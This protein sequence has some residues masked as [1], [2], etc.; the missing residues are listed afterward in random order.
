MTKTSWLTGIVHTLEAY[1]VPRSIGFDNDKSLVKKPDVYIAELS[2]AMRELCDYYGIDPS[3]CRIKN[4]RT[5]E[6]LKAPAE[7]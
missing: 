7:L 2:A 4:H 3:S 1:G 5:R 6:L